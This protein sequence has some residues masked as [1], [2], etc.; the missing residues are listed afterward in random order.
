M[1]TDYAAKAA[2][3]TAMLKRYGM[4]L[5]IVRSTPSGAYDPGTGDTAPA[6][7]STF[8]GTGAKFNYEQ[9]DVDGTLVKQGDQQLYLSVHQSDGTDMPLPVTG[10]V[11]LIGGK[12]FRVEDVSDIEPTT[13]PLLFICQI[14]GVK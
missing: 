7:T 6:V 12:R 3:A 1:A 11:A 13:V 4:D 5:E 14:R 9:D 2:R 8:P 10:D